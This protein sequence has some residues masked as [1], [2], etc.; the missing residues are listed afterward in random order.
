MQNKGLII[1]ISG[2]SGVGKTT[3]A[4]KLLADKQFHG[5]IVRSVSA[6]TRPPRPS[7][8]EGRDYYF[9]SEKKFL[10]LERAGRFLESKKLFQFYYGTP[11]KKVDD[12]LKKGISVLLCI[13]VQGAQDVM[14]KYQNVLGIFIKPPTLADLRKRLCLRNTENKDDLLSRLAIAKQELREARHYHFVLINDDLVDAYKRLK[15]I[16]AAKI[17]DR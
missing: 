8:R 9:I 13:D 10:S 11:K 4:G 16:I 15:K 14:H 12:F 2:P 7:E 5:K 6:T 1:I 17:A 3:L